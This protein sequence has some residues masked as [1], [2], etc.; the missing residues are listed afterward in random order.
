MA[1]R[2]GARTTTTSHAVLD[3]DLIWFCVPDSE[4][5]K[6]AGVLASRVD[7]RGKTAFHS[8]G[9]LPSDELARLRKQGASV[10]AVHPLMTFVGDSVPALEGVAFAA[11]GDAAALRMA[12]KITRAFSGEF[13]LIPKAHKAAYH[14]FGAFASPLLIALLATTEQVAKAAGMSRELA[15]KR[16]APIVT[17]TLANYTRLGA[18]KSFSGPVVRGDAEVVK[19]HLKVLKKIPEAMRVYEALAGA[20][21]RYLPAQNRKKLKSLLK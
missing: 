19:K 10:A 20:A 9:A 3:A 17:Q 12:R 4:I 16:M 18:A 7:W 2:V 21:L 11:E 5:A 1:R 13:F 14:A 15:R 6:S 8:S